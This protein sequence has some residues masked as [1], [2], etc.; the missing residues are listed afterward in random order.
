VFG[1]TSKPHRYTMLSCLFNTDDYITSFYTYQL[2]YRLGKASLG[3][4][5]RSI[6][7]SGV[8]SSLHIFL[9]FSNIVLM[10]GFLHPERE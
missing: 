4:A 1:G 7:D 9:S 6:K 5:D 3:S 10:A 8:P 2:P